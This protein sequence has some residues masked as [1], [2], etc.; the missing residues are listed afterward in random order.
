MVP[1]LGSCGTENL[2]H[3]ACG[4][5]MGQAL[6]LPIEQLLREIA[7]Q[8]LGTVVRRFHDFATAEDAVQEA[9]LAAAAGGSSRQSPGLADSGRLAAHDGLPA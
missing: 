2:A 8:V 4:A 5:V 9:L 1:R 6:G 7:S 3:S